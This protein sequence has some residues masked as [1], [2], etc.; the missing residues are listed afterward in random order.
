MLI[1][2]Y[3][4]YYLIY[5]YIYSGIYLLFYFFIVI[6]INFFQ[7]LTSSNHPNHQ[8]LAAREQAEQYTGNMRSKAESAVSL[9]RDKVA[10]AR[11]DEEERGGLVV[12]EARYGVL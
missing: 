2:L 12:V 9:M 1:Y 6:I 4:Y 8:I 7:I 3:F 5:A 11:Q 10:K